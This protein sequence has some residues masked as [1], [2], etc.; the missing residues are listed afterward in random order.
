MPVDYFIDETFHLAQNSDRQT[1]YVFAVVG[2]DRRR[3]AELS[4]Q[5]SGK[6]LGK[7]WHSIEILSRPN[8]LQKFQ[9][10][11]S[12]F[13]QLQ[14]FI[15]QVSPLGISDRTGEDARRKLIFE[16]VGRLPGT[17]S[18]SF[19]IFEKRAGGQLRMDKESLSVLRS[20]GF[21]NLRMKSPESEKILWLADALAYAY[22]RYF[23]TGDSSLLDSFPNHVSISTIS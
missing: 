4:N 6:Y 18:K 1:F 12:S 16:L 23:L 22:R 19:A 9:N 15:Y 13:D 20:Q 17:S 14:L 7:R 3:L 5:M 8:G 2:V 21:L 10:F 11:V